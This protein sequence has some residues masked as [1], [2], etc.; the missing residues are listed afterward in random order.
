MGCVTTFGTNMFSNIKS[1]LT[2][3]TG[4]LRANLGSVVLVH[5]SNENVA[6]P[7]HPF[8]DGHKL[9]K[10]SVKTMLRQHPPSPRPKINILDKY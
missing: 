5:F 7:S 9:P 6:L 3:L 10:G 4:A 2:C 8:K 1:L